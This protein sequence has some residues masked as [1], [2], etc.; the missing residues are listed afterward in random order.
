MEGVASKMKKGL[1]IAG[2]VLG[3]FIIAGFCL[4]AG[5]T[6]SAK[7]ELNAMVYEKAD[8]A[9]V[10]DGTYDGEADAGL[11]YVK[12]GVTV[13]A[14]ALQDIKILEHRNGMGSKAES[15]TKAMVDKNSYKVDA[16]SGATLSSEAIKSAVSKALKKGLLP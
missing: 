14:H 11:V 6:N 3:I 7:K 16:V 1:K 4:Y 12:V 2:I 8:L 13:K 5:M 10:Q 15:I 9:L